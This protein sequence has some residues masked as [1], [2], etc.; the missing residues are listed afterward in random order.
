M[1]RTTISLPDELHEELRREAFRARLSMAEV[2][3]LRIQTP[4]IA[5][6]KRKAVADPLLK[7]AGICGGRVI[8]ANIDDELSR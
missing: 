4:A 5:P 3:R 7:V 2:I 6:G 8:S 1:R